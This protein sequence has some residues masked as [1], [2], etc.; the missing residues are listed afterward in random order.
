MGRVS[1]LGM[2]SRGAWGS[3]GLEWMAAEAARRRLKLMSDCCCP[4]R[5]LTEDMARLR[6]GLPA[7]HPSI[8]IRCFHDFVQ[9]P[10]M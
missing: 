1:T 3:A 8:S 4:P 7:S 10:H 2:L 9:R 5:R 6:Y